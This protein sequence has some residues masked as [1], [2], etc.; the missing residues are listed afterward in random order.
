MKARLVAMLA[1]AGLLVAGAA[2]AAVTQDQAFALI[3]D[4]KMDCLNCHA[5]DKKVVGPAWKDVGAKY[6]AGD[7][8]KLVEKIKKGGSGAWGAIPMTPHPTASD[9]DLGKLVD[10]ILSLK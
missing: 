8:A 9:D 5:V 1:G 2:N 10:F 7:K 6:G 3:K 4:K